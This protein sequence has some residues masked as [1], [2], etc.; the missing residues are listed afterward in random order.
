MSWIRGSATDYKDLSNAIV[1]AA[2]EESLSTVD[3][4]A[5]GGTG[6]TVGD[7]LTL[8]GGTYTVQAQVEVTTVAAGVVTAVRRYNDGVYTVT[9]TDPVSTTGGTGTGCT[10][11]CTFVANGWVADRDGGDTLSTVDSIAAG[12]TGYTVND[13]LS[14]VGG[15]YST[16]ATVTVATVSGGVVTG[17]TITTAGA[18]T[19][20]P[21]DPVSTTGGTGSGCTL[22]CTFVAAGEREVVLRGSGGGTDTIYVGW[23]TFSSVPGGYYNWE[24]HGMTGYS[25]ALPFSEQPGISPGF[26]DA[27]VADN[28]HGAYLLCHNTTIQ[29]WLSINAYRII[30]VIKVGSAY[31][32]AY[33]GWGN[34]F[35]TVGEIPYPLFIAGHTS[36]YTGVSSQS[37]LSSGLVDPWRSAQGS[38]AGPAFM[39]GVDNSWYSVANGLVDVGSR[40]TLTDRIV[41]PTQQN[42]GVTSGLTPAEDKFMGNEFIFTHVILST[43]LSGNTTAFLHETPGQTNAVRVLLPAFIVFFSP[44]QIMMDLDDVYWVSAFGSMTSE[45][46]VIISGVVYR[47]FQNCNRT[48]SYAYLAVKEN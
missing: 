6:Y 34:Q 22:N 1:E 9:P 39:L 44:I 35:G 41:M 48:D 46:R 27:S 16:Q 15:I 26:Y 10:L 14:L 8:S 19:V 47:V 20:L 12:G 25:S 2:T 29:Y 28:K 30:L 31:F 18:Y 23:R 21:T 37:K 7:I 4:I 43:G 17:V 13:V 32:N 5:A 42:T 40:T 36:E 33:L 45:D 24:L 3:S 38:I 11:N